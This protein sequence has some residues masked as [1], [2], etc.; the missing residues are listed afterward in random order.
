MALESPRINSTRRR[1]RRFARGRTSRS[2]RFGEP[3]LSTLEGLASKARELGYETEAERI[4]EEP[5][6]SF[7]QRLGKG[8][9]AFNP[10]EAFLVGREQGLGR[11]LLEYPKGIATGLGSAITG[12][13]YEPER[14]YFREV[15]E[16]LGV[17]NKIAK[18][19]VGFLG[20]VLLDPTTYFGGA[21][22]KGMGFTIKGA[23]RTALGGLERVNPLAASSLRTSA[24]AAKD[25]LGSMF[26]AGYKT[27]EGLLGDTMR[28]FNKKGAAAKGIATRNLEKLGTGTLSANQKEEIFTRLAAGKRLEFGLRE[29]YN[30]SIGDFI[31]QRQIA[32][33]VGGV[34]SKQ[35]LEGTS[36]IV[37]ETLEEQ[38][39]RSKILGQKLVG[40]DF[41]RS[42]FPFIR[43]DK[44]QRF[45]SD[46]RGVRIGSQP[47]KKQFKNLITDDLLETDPA[48]AF[49]TVETQIAN[50]SI[51]RSFLKDQVIP[52]YGK[53][54]NAFKNETDAY[55]N[56]YKLLREKGA[57]GKELGWIPEWDKKFLD[58][59][60][61]PEYK[62][63]DTLAKATGFDAITSLFKRSVTGL[64]APFHVRN[65]VSGTI[66]NYETIGIQALNPAT[67]S[68]GQKL[69]LNVVKGKTTMSGKWGK[70]L[71]PFLER[72]KESS[73][74]MNEFDEIQKAGTTLTEYSKMFSKTAFKR[75]LKTGGLSGDSP[76]FKAARAVGNY[77][78]LQQKA[79]VYIGALSLGKTT[80]QALA[81]AERAGFDYRVL[82]KFESRILRRIVPFYSFTRKN[83]G[84]QLS[85]LKENPERI[86]HL[87]ALVRNVG[88]RIS[89]E[90]KRDLPQYLKESLGIKL[91]DTPDGLKQYIAS[92]G[93]P[94]EAF[95]SLINSNPVLT[96][97]SM[98]N[99]VLKVPIELGIGKDSFRKR[100]L[101]DV[102]TANEYEL[103]PQPIKDLLELE[104]VEKDIL[105]KGRDG[106]LKKVGTRTE[107]QANPYRLLIAR[108]L[109]TS[110][111]IT[112][113]D[114]F[115]G[116]DLEGFV[117]V[118]KTTTG[119]NPQQVN[120]EAYKAYDEKLKRRE[121]QDL[122]IRRGDV[123]AF[124]SVY[125]PK[126]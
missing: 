7:L 102:Y 6:L 45:L 49:N 50:D 59:M 108:S 74:Y 94:V 76:H 28:M 26:K 107:W 77:I 73:F 75:A 126:E 55:A 88:D 31:P 36:G 12:K 30:D 109:F 105:K 57:S 5:K 99:P 8:L 13:D 86:N 106:K 97:I 110:R 39:R 125:I 119:V 124:E 58:D 118:I 92:F 98:T 115:F 101:K 2:K 48:T 84:L 104:R 103:M 64:F 90:E 24:G 68:S 44:L 87:I 14:R 95:T 123:R 122:L 91:S 82:T 15:A 46:T 47:Y 116:N 21:L 83:I 27:Q 79:T 52:Q 43:K 69:A 53:P 20:D 10:A 33:D 111:G 67:I 72:F 65:Y 56:G 71:K 96:G 42:Y 16:E 32:E 89:P 85:T 81:L 117:K 70:Q 114:Q 38:M 121:F 9:G 25:A 93:T 22:V 35:V 113:F 23:G 112:Y 80:K 41:Y 34:V 11:G 51:T 100:D 60:L 29:I 18:F 37:R 3:D 4:L 78:E 120:L 54:L 66:Q 61:S 63:I 40:D 17:E 62:T 1:S 19:G